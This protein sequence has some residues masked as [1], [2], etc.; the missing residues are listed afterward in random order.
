MTP[1]P[2]DIASLGIAYLWVRNQQSW[3]LPHKKMTHR[4]V[5]LGSGTAAFVYMEYYMIADVVAF[6]CLK[7]SEMARR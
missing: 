7:D 1:F 4:M 5:N 6:V 3:A 2:Y